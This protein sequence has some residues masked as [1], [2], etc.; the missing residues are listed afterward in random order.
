MVDVEM[1]VKIHPVEVLLFITSE[2][3]KNDISHSWYASQDHIVLMDDLAA[4]R[5][6]PVRVTHQPTRRALLVSWTLDELGKEMRIFGELVTAPQPLR[7]EYEWVLVLVTY[8]IIISE[9][10]S[11]M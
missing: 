8:I 11:N 1:R 3:T 2:G 9:I 7:V 4:Q 10:F 5:V 6:L